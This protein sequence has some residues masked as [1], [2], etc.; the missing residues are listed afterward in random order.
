MIKTYKWNNITKLICA[1]AWTIVFIIAISKPDIDTKTPLL[2][3][4]GLLVVTS[5]V[6]FIIGRKEYARKIK[7]SNN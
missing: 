2:I 4:V 5:L 6:D 3:I 7:R 1:L